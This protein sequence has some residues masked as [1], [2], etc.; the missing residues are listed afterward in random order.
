MD[1]RLCKKRKRRTVRGHH[2]ILFILF[3]RRNDEIQKSNLLQV[4]R[5]NYIQNP[6]QTNEYK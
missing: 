4:N 2:H 1:T 5:V 6:I 3:P